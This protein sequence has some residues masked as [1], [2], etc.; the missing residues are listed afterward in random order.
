MK[1][2]EKGQGR[3]AQD[4]AGA[5]LASRKS[6]LKAKGTENKRRKPSLLEQAMGIALKA[7]AGQPD[8]AGSP[9]IL[10]PLRVMLA[11]DRIEE[12]I[13]GVLHDVV[14]DTP[15]TLDDLRAA[16]IPEEAVRLVDLLTRRPGQG[17]RDY[18]RRIRPDPA[19][20]RIKL[21]DLDDN[22]DARRLRRITAR[23]ARRMDR[24]R[25]WKAR[26]L[27]AQAEEERLRTVSSD[28]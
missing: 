11:L 9:Y 16:G 2:G 10:H 17:K 24:Y 20:R 21:A 27:L 22:L 5:R 15:L 28:R 12:R 18:Y 25:A 19:A 13:A 1:N 14:E 26:L 3:T 8:K 4:L 7:H 6:R 23:D